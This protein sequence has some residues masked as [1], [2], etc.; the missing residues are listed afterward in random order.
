MD[1]IGYFG[2]AGVIILFSILF[3]PKIVER[4]QS[5]TMVEHN[6]ATSAEP[7]SYIQ[8]TGQTKNVPAFT[9]LNQ[10]S[11]FI[12]NE[13]YK[14]KVYVAEFFFTSCPTICPIMNKNMKLIEEK[15][16]QRNDFGIASFSI[17][18]DHDS[19]SVLKLYAEK[20]DVFSLNWHF[21]TGEKEKI[22]QLANSGFNIYAG[23]NPD[24]AGGFEHQGYFALID[25]D[26]FIRSRTDRFDN[27]IVYYVGID[28]EDGSKEQVEW[29][30]EDIDKLLLE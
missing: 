13:D 18:P 29:L 2:I 17:D 24:I 28:Q 3:I 1:K 8:L 6:R 23:I 15:F 11:L 22:Y 5:D 26:G 20:Y 14:D 25:K 10:D 30:I 16:G 21:L 27:P 19:P 9:F 7:L 4:F 12:S